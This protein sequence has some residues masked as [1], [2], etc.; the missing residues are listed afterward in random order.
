MQCSLDSQHNAEFR[1][2]WPD[3]SQHWMLGKGEV[4]QYDE[5]QRPLRMLGVN[6]DITQRK[7]DEERLAT[8]M[9]DMQKL[10]A[11]LEAQVEER[12]EVL[13]HLNAELQRSNQELQDFAYVASHDL[14]EPLRKFRPLAICSKKSME[15]CWKMVKRI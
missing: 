9:Q 11:T 7:E 14:Q 3:G 2:I 15:M 4:T 10:N 13:R 1:V 6:I 5:Q 8:M 12:T